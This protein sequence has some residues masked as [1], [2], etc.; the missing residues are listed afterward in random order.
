MDIWRRLASVGRLFA[1]LFVSFGALME[2]SVGV[3]IGGTDGDNCDNG[4]SL[5]LVVRYEYA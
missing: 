5:L 1:L 3:Y 4:A 2:V